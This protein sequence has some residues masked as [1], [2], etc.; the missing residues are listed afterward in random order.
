MMAKISL[1]D[2]INTM[3]VI[4]NI[5][6]YMLFSNIRAAFRLLILSKIMSSL[7]FV[8]LRKRE[9]NGKND[10]DDDGNDNKMEC[11]VIE[12]NM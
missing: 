8:K 11:F 5:I 10:D 9:E 2:V 12:I 3:F 6:V 4:L 7:H 1:N